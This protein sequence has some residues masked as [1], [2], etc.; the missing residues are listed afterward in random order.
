M[1][2]LQ[3]TGMKSLMSL[4]NDLPGTENTVTAALTMIK[5]EKGVILRMVMAGEAN[6]ERRLGAAIGQGKGIETGTGT[7]RIVIVTE[8]GTKTDHM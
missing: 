2:K 4:G 1:T 7:G 8:T 6:T 3:G 5:I